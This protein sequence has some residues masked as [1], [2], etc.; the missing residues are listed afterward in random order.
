MR[1]H[2]ATKIGNASIQVCCRLFPF[3]TDGTSE[4]IDILALG[5]LFFPT[6]SAAC[7]GRPL[8]PPVYRLS[9]GRPANTDAT[10]RNTGAFREPA[11]AA[12][13]LK[14]PVSNAAIRAVRVD[15]RCRSNRPGSIPAVGSFFDRH[16]PIMQVVVCLTSFNRTDCA[17][18]SLEII[19][20]NW[21]YKWPVVHA[22]SGAGYTRYI[23][24]VLVQREPLP[25]TAGAADLLLASMRAAVAHFGA[26]YVVH[27]EADTW[28][29]DQKVIKRYLQALAD[30][31]EAVIAASSWSTDCLPQWTRSPSRGRRLRAQLARVLRPLGFR[32]GVRER[33]SISTQFFIARATPAFMD[34]LADIRVKDDDFLEKIL[35]SAVVERFGQRSIIGMKEREPVHPVFRSSCEPL[36][37]YCQHWPSAEDAPGV[38]IAPDLN[39]ADRLRGKKECLASAPLMR[40]GPYMQKLL[41]STDLDYYNGNARRSG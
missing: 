32:Y 33:K 15:A 16:S 21:A 5:T 3:E 14:F 12:P 1:P 29:F 24:D 41:H 36:T 2:V 19:K 22:C 38:D 31:P 6:I 20:L 34:M 23:E 8:K 17:R 27:L 25:L 39:P 18:I 30:R 9:R 4:A 35:Y 10:G 13:S 40:H 11:Q 28:V 26:E 37:L 7:F